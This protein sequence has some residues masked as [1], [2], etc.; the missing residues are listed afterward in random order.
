VQGYFFV[1]PFLRVSENIPFVQK[2]FCNGALRGYASAALPCDF[3]C[4]APS[5][6]IALK[7]TLAADFFTIF[8]FF[9]LASR[10]TWRYNLNK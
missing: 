6:E 7:L 4:D 9:A 10:G 3:A 5:H 2:R 1:A 8:S